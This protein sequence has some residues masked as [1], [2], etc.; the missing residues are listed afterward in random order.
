MDAKAALAKVGY[1]EEDIKNGFAADFSSLEALEGNTSGSLEGYLY[2][3][4]YQFY[5][6]ES[7]KNIISTYVNGLDKVIKENDLK[8][9]FEAQGLSLY[10]GIVLASIVQK[11]AKAAEKAKANQKKATDRLL[12]NILGSAGSAIGRNITNKIFK[13]IFKK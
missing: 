10:E 7:V 2:G 3:E 8:A 4:T 13:D 6:G 5:E 1:S 11:E 12:G 9:K